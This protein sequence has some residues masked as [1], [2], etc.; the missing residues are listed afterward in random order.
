MRATN[1]WYTSDMI[2]RA[3]ITQMA[4]WQEALGRPGTDAVRVDGCT[5]AASLHGTRRL[6]FM[7]L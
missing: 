6:R 7:K 5:S 3:C 1:A 2:T 4:L